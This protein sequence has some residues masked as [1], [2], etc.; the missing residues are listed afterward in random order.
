MEISVIA[1]YDKTTGKLHIV[2]SEGAEWNITT[3]NPDTYLSAI[4]AGS[5][6]LEFKRNVRLIRKKKHKFKLAY[7]EL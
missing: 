1:E 2:N 4:I 7:K 5:L 3:P 6:V